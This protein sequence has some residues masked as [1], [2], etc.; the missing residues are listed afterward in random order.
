MEKLI[1]VTISVDED[2][3]ASNIEFYEPESGDFHRI[4]VEALDKETALEV[5][6]EIID[7]ISMVREESEQGQ[8][9]YA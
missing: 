8:E 5:G 1:E 3:G 7:W 9:A 6:E 4:N 2:T